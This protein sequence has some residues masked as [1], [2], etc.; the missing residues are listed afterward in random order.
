MFATRFSYCTNRFTVIIS[1]VYKYMTTRVTVRSSR[2]KHSTGAKAYIYRRFKSLSQAACTEYQSGTLEPLYLYICNYIRK[3][4]VSCWFCISCL[5]SV[6]LDLVSDNELVPQ[7]SFDVL[8][9]GLNSLYTDW[10][11]SSVNVCLSTCT[12]FACVCYFSQWL[13]LCV[14]VHWA[15]D[16]PVNLFAS[17]TW[18]SNSKHALLVCWYLHVKHNVYLG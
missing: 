5:E 1:S 3:I 16:P 11:E 14:F 2:H 10:L 8:W 9:I 13:L 17:V 4:R 7:I 18:I 15:Y 12:M 6:N